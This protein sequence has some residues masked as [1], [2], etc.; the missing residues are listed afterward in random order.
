[1]I[2]MSVFVGRK[3]AF[4]V[5]SVQ[6]DGLCTAGAAAKGDDLL[7]GVIDVSH[8]GDTDQACFRLT[9]EVFPC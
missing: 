4:A 9:A 6:V 7:Q 3:R 8:R 5:A 2:L 1:M